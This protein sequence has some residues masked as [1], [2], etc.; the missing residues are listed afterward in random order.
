MQTTAQGSPPTATAAMT[1]LG[2]MVKMMMKKRVPGREKLSNINQTYLDTVSSSAIWRCC[3]V[4]ADGGVENLRC[5][6]SQT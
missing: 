4:R 3:E 1:R 5:R 6:C 2:I